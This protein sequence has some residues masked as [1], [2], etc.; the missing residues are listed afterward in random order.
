MERIQSW[1]NE[2]ARTDQ[3]E[4]ERGTEEKE[5][6]SVRVA[7]ETMEERREARMAPRAANLIGTVTKTK[8]PM[9]TKAKGKAKATTR[10]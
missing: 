9:G 4:Q 7:Q 8:D 5:L 2:Q 3:T 10:W 6:L 1:Q